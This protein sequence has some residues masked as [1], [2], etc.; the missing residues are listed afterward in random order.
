MG[1]DF[2]DGVTVLPLT[3]RGSLG[4]PTVVGTPLP[5]ANLYLFGNETAETDIQ[6]PPGYPIIERA[7]QC[8][9]QHKLDMDYGVGKYY[10]SNLPRGTIVNDSAANIW[11]VLS[12]M[13]TRGAAGRCTFEYTMESISFD[14]P[15]DDFQLN[16]VS[17]DLNIIKHPRY[18]WALLPYVSDASTYTTVGDTNIYYTDI[19]EA[20]VRMIQNYTDSP[21]YPSATQVQGLIQSNIMAMLNL[22]VGQTNG[23]LQINYA[24]SAY[25]GSLPTVSPVPWD[26]TNANR[27]TANCPYF[28]VSVPFDLTNPANPITIAI[29]AAKELI[30]KLW[31][32]E[33]TP[34]IAGY[35][36]VWTQYFFAPV[37]LNPGG[38]IQDPR[39][40]VPQYFMSPD[41]NGIIPRANQND[42]FGGDSSAPL[43]SHGESIFDY[44]TEYN[45]QCYAT[46]GL[47]GG[48][49]ALSCLR[50]SD[51]YDYERTWFKV[52]H[53]WLCAPIGRWDKDIYTSGNRPQIAT[54]FNINPASFG[55]N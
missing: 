40:W 43:G 35:E 15:P 19:K 34:Y 30:S 31:R 28:A 18:S 20:I 42:A 53:T 14:S 48:P 39:D 10:W 49:L 32:Q 11:R 24:N 50:K 47:R 17:L 3:P 29:A 27:P 16:E 6:E 9:C 51:H 37:Y 44:L 2:A 52:P 45:P 5:T 13:L 54:D 22:K 36:I 33:D 38:F 26:G 23:K 25:D 8:T 41:N 1:I 21:F 4:T 12:C 55:A 7:E 46:N